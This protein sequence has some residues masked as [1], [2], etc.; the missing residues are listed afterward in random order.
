MSITY[1]FVNEDSN[2]GNHLQNIYIPAGGLSTS[3]N[4][5]LKPLEIYV[6][7]AGVNNIDRY[8]NGSKD[9]TSLGGKVIT[10]RNNSTGTIIV[11]QFPHQPAYTFEAKMYN[12]TGAA[13]IYIEYSSDGVNFTR[14]NSYT[15]GPSNSTIAQFTIPQ[16][17]PYL[18][19]NI[20]AN[21]GQITILST[22]RFGMVH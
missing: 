7:S 18:R 21:T 17:Y 15:L 12:N 9:N 2:N 6:G 19:F 14:D 1:K 8:V 16:W 20:T 5:L 3:N 11:D 4:T 13:T 22:S 10:Y